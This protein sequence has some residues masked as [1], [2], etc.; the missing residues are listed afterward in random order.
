MYWQV[1]LHKTGIAAEQILIRTLQRA[2][3]LNKT[4]KIKASNTLQYFLDHEISMENFN[5]STLEI[6]SRL[7]DFD[8]ISALKEW[9]HH[10]DFVLS[11][12]SEMIIN[13]NLLRIKLKNKKIKEVD[14]STHLQNVMDFYKISE[15]EA[16][17]FVF[18]GEISNQACQLNHHKINILHKSGK[19]EDI[20][21][22]SDL[23]NVKALAKPITKY[24]ICYPKEKL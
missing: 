5:E 6:F 10:P 18:T 23:L 19:I 8:I 21:K 13:R 12:L 16:A 7:D 2:K 20:V 3:E 4:E 15:N 17:Y 1:Y 24:Y 14:L 11:R 22:A 9:Q